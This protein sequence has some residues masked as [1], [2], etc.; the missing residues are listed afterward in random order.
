MRNQRESP[1]FHALSYQ[2]L[3]IAGLPDDV[4]GI[5]NADSMI[6]STRFLISSSALLSVSLFLTDDGRAQETS[7]DAGLNEWRQW[8]GPLG[9]GEA[10]TANPP[11][12]WS[13]TENV[14]WKTALPGLGHS[15][16]IVVG[17]KVFVTTAEPFGDEFEPRYSQAEGAHDNAPVKQPY[18]FSVIGI[19]R[20]NGEIL[21]QKTIHEAVPFDGR[22]HFTASLASAS[23]VTDGKFVYASFGSY[24]LFCLDFDGNI[25]WQKTL[26][27]M[28][29]KHGHGEGASPAIFEDT[30][31]I[32]WDHEGASFVVALNTATGEERW[33]SERDELT[34][35]SSPIVYEHDGTVQ[36]FVAGTNRVRGYDL[37]TGAVI[38]ECGGLSS[39]IVS[40]PVAGDGMVFTGSS[41]EIR[42]LFAIR[43]EGARG[44]IT[45]TENVA[46]KIHERTPYV[47]SPL[48]YRG[49]LYFLRHYQGI[50][51]RF[52]AETGEEKI[53][54]FRLDGVRDIYASPVA[55]D[56]RIY[57]SDRDGVTIVFTHAEDPVNDASRMLSANK[58]DDRISA[59]VALA[60]NQLFIRGE[61]A[62]Y[63][64]AEKGD[65]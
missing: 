46:W 42:S 52:E 35:W 8:R 29:V 28:Q 20:E 22:G 43:L 3:I 55:A 41:Y 57:I 50:L 34:S 21:W 27:Q 40:T 58:I 11:I 61:K 63:C 24:G 16:P 1:F 14:V 30:L 54:P 31:I 37:K 13:E 5:Q 23:P 10:P 9:T 25:V 7:F 33:R 36:V 2:V 59:S 32:N 65:E 48:L 19:N 15:T 64:V 62:L 47:P 26:G 39:N 4:L 60:G 17:D 44:D 18:R 12:T 38:W 51:S 56:G 53:G 49:S 45:D 6:I